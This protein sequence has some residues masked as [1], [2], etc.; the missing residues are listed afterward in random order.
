MVQEDAPQG[1]PP[2]GF[3]PRDFPTFHDEA[4]I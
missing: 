2:Q 4:D 3:P 1:F